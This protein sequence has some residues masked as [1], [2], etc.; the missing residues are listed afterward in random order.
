MPDN[1]DIEE[2][3][4]R[5]ILDAAEKVFVVR[6]ID[7]ARMDDI[8]EESG[9]SKGALYWYFKSKDA[10]IRAVVDRVFIS[11]MREAETLVSA[12]GSASERLKTFVGFAVR[13]YKRI[14]K[15]LPLAYEFVALAARS[16]TVRETVVIYFNR[17]KDILADVIQ[18]GID[19]GEFKPCDPKTMAISV[20]SM[21]EGMAM[22]WFIEPNL[23]DWDVMG[24]E[25]I[26]TILAGL[27]LE[28]G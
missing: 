10:I 24:L 18:Q 15:L 25:P 28:N 20:I 16:K 1:K 4:R 5:Q 9:L 26:E 8:V 14:E 19:R 2:T 12:E 27:A 23:V 17:Y 7:K 11:E 13:E 22:L 21:Y 6:G 3:R